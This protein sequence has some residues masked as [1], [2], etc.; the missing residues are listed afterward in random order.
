MNFVEKFLKSVMF[1]EKADLVKG[2]LRNYSESLKSLFCE[3]I[4]FSPRNFPTLANIERKKEMQT[5]KEER[6][7]VLT[8]QQFG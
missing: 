3:T 1:I 2:E 6:G 8:T 5:Q 7:E 4:F